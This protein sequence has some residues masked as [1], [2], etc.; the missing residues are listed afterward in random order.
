VRGRNK[1]PFYLVLGGIGLVAVGLIAWQ[2]SRPAELPVI[3]IDPATP[4]PEA[5]GYLLGE[6]SAP[7]QILEF[8]DF[9]CPACGTFATLTEPDMRKRLVET[10][11]ASFRFLDFP[12]AM[13]PNSWAASMAAACA[14]E[15]GRFWEMHDGIFATQHEWNG[16]VTTR[17]RA[18]FA[19]LVRDLGLNASQWNECFDTQKYKLDIAANQRAGDKYMVSSTPTF[20]IGSKVVRGALGFDELRAYVDSAAAL[21]PAIQP[22]T[23]GDTALRTGIP[24]Q[25]LP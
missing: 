21:A 2:A 7:V 9:E 15:Q 5:S 24:K 18:I 22:M 6:A 10:G 12:L 20:V 3:T 23:S 17:P 19:R 13:H 25:K 14:N 11:R 4:L 1:T 16:T 8:A